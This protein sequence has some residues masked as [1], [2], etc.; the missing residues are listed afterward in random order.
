MK[1]VIQSYYKGLSG[2]TFKH[3]EKALTQNLIDKLIDVMG[4]DRDMEETLRIQDQDNMDDQTFT[5][6]LI[7]RG[8]KDKD[9]R[10]LKRSRED[11]TMQSGPHLGGFNQQISVPE[12]ID[13]LFCL[14]SMCIS[15]R[16]LYENGLKGR[17]N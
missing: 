4:I 17:L 10:C 1:L 6:F 15:D 5:D 9:V 7:S 14:S 12:L 2:S 16:Y 8:Y 11:I 3:I 13:L